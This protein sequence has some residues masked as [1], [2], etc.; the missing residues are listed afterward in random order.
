M[1]EHD[2]AIELEHLAGKLLNV[3]FNHDNTIFCAD[4]IEMR[5]FYDAMHLLLVL[6]GKGN[7]LDFIDYAYKSC[8][9]KNMKEIKNYLDIYNMFLTYIN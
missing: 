1:N 5:S 7:W 6:K 3:D 8:F 2:V 4:I 9:N